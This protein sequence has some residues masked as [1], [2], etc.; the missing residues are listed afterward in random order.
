MYYTAL[1][2]ALSDGL[3]CLCCLIC[4]LSRH[5]L[6]S[7]RGT[8]GYAAFLVLPLA[9]YRILLVL[10]ALSDAPVRGVRAVRWT[11]GAAAACLPVFFEPLPSSMALALPRIAR[12]AFPCVR[13]LPPSSSSSHPLARL[14]SAT[15]ISA[16]SS[17]FCR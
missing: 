10:A 16:A 2:T 1:V 12:T 8:V 6:Y 13:P 7:R 17:V 14:L 5:A 15:R 11:A 9:P 3:F 4:S